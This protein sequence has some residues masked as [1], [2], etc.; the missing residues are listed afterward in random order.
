MVF[1]ELINKV[2]EIHVCPAVSPLSLVY[3]FALTAE[4][5]DLDST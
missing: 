1:S 4:R 5:V 3:I 2:K